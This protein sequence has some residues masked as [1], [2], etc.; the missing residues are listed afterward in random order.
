[1]A[2]FFKHISQISNATDYLKILK[3]ALPKS[4]EEG[5]LFYEKFPFNDKEGPALLIGEILPTV[6]ADIKKVANSSA[7]GTIALTED[8]I[9]LQ[10]TQGKVKYEAV[11]KLITEKAKFAVDVRITTEA[12]EG[13]LLK[14]KALGQEYVGEDKELGWRQKAWNK[15]VEDRTTDKVT[16]KY[17]TEEE[18]KESELSVSG[19]G[20]LKHDGDKL[21]GKHGFVM[22]PKTGS[23]HVFES[24]IEENGPDRLKVTHHSSPLS[25]GD[26]A[27]AGHITAKRGVVTEI[28]DASGHY[29]PSADLT[30]QAVKHLK[31]TGVKLQRD[32]VEDHKGRKLDEYDV[33][34]KDFER[35]SSQQELKELLKT[36][37]ELLISLQTEKDT[38]S[39]E[40]ALSEIDDKIID[41]NRIIKK[42]T[43]YPAHK[44]AKV[45]LQG[46]EGL[47]EEEFQEVAGDMDL[48][49]ALLEEKFGIKN[50]IDDSNK[51]NMENRVALNLLIGEK[52]K[53]TMLV[54]Q[55][56]VS[57]GNETTIR[58]KDKLNQEL[59]RLG[60]IKPSDVKMVIAGLKQFDE[61]G[62]EEKIASLELDGEA[63]TMKEK[64]QVLK[65]EIS[66]EEALLLWRTEKSYHKTIK[67][68][69]KHIDQE[70]L[71][72]E[73][74]DQIILGMISVEE[75]ERRW[76]SSASIEKEIKK[77]KKGDRE[78]NQ[79]L[80]DMGLNYYLM[81]R[82]L[83][84]Q[85]LRGEETVTEEMLKEWPISSLFK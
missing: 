53:K 32:T 30:Y 68:I 12:E 22:D 37:E 36:K 20:K 5:F 47:S 62:G 46:K 19:S 59:A 82:M 38:D 34:D 72:K 71:T 33:V 14:R 18:R 70:A 29:K 69:S 35:I 48:L 66:V 81:P 39:I 55:F 7:K 10:V 42:N 3:T 24:K 1:M 57:E 75:A 43:V 4:N 54:S 49:N 27:A 23:T 56:L 83:K 13:D 76:R 6:M 80:E 51:R 64:I 58:Q 60:N 50:M 2:A 31:E 25:G 74:K 45:S 52:T 77:I 21:D 65:G 26:V 11:N 40:E 16:T 9:T 17:F 67:A 44:E 84:L 41:L 73:E 63:M 28:D 78:G 61:L 79:I 8:K 85:I 15:P